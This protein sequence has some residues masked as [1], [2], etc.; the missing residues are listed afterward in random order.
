MRHPEWKSVDVVCEQRSTWDNKRPVF[1]K[2]NN[3]CRPRLMQQVQATQTHR[4]SDGGTQ[5]P[6]ISY[7]PDLLPVAHTAQNFRGSEWKR[8]PVAV[9]GQHGPAQQ[10]EVLPSSLGAFEAKLEHAL[11]RQLVDLHRESHPQDKNHT[12][13]KMWF[14]VKY[15]N[16]KYVFFCTNLHYYRFS[17]TDWR[18]LWHHEERGSWLNYFKWWWRHLL[19]VTPDLVPER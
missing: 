3:N 5:N 4:V 2:L 14:S 6:L 18:T 9:E 7:A 10:L 17:C 8:L 12:V 11:I 15:H 19:P 13:K 1:N 16:E